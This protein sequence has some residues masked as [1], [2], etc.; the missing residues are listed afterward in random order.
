MIVGTPAY[1][2]PEQARGM[3][4]LDGRSDIYSLGVMVY[5]MLSG[6]LPYPAKGVSIWQQIAATMLMMHGGNRFCRVHTPYLRG[7]W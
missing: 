5:Q 7:A 4:D 3:A 1:M 6:A 2:S